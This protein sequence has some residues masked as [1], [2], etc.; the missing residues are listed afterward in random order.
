MRILSILFLSLFLSSPLFA[1]DDGPVNINS[2]DAETLVQSLQGVGP[3]KA[4]AIVRYRETYGDF[5]TIEELESVKG[6]GPSIVEKNRSHITL[7]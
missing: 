2:A 1:I 6:I 7:K 4:E 3:A 5:E